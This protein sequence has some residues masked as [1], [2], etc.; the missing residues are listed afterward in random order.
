VHLCDYPAGN[1]AAID[2]Q[3]SDR[4]RVLRDIASLGRSARMDNKLKVRQ[5]LARVEV[6]LSD[7]KHQAWLESHDQLLRDELNVKR[8]EYTRNAEEF[9]NYLVQPNFKRLG[10]RIGKRLP[11][12]KQALAQGS[13]G[14]FLQQLQKNGKVELQIDGEIVA[15]DQEDIQI[16]LEAKPGWAAAQSPDCVVVLA[17][18]LTPD[19]LREGYANDL[20]RLI[21]DRRKELG[22]QYTDRI[23]VGIAGASGELLAAIEQ[24]Q[25]SIQEETL[26]Q[27]LSPSP[28]PDAEAVESEVADQP[29]QLFVRV[30]SS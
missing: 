22:C 30:A 12:V 29:I 4:M 11:G 2:P 23:Q 10:P 25:A 5:P 14:Q 26:A 27:E 16:R 18:E 3:L 1:D 15:L 24:F 9:I 19:L 21:Q 17:T 13:G 20:I 7:T 6:V 28:V 8:I